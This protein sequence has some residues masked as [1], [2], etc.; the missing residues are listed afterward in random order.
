MNAAQR[1]P[2][3][4]ATRSDHKAG[5]IREI[6]APLDLFV[7]TLSDLGVEAVPE[8]ETIEVYTTFQANAIAKA[9]YFASRL[10]RTAISDDSGLRVDALGGAPGVRTKRFSG[11]SDLSGQ[12]LDH[13][14]NM[15]LLEK[16]EGVPERERTA[17]YV[18]AAAIAW[19]DGRAFT[20]TGTVAGVI[21]TELRG[22]G[23]FGYDPLFQV[24]ELGARFSEVAPELKDAMSHRSRAFRALATALDAS[25]WAPAP[26]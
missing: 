24:P 21:A 3:L 12:P 25:P 15:L 17:R 19:P 2:I 23:G 8:E 16:L 22:E 9:R 11:R 10:G 7:Q 1:A 13:A 18:C 20:A 14:N 5:E 26:G 4:L 6:L